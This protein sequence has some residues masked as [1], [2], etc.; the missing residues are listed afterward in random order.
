M[1]IGSSDGLHA[2]LR[3]C[4]PTAPKVPLSRGEILSGNSQPCHVE[5]NPCLSGPFSLFNVFNNFFCGVNEEF[6]TLFRVSRRC[7]TLVWI[8]F[9]RSEKRHRMRKS[10]GKLPNFI[11]VRKT[12]PGSAQLLGPVPY[13]FLTCGYC[14]N[15]QVKRGSVEK[16]L[17]PYSATS[18]VSVSTASSASATSASSSTVSSSVTPTR[19]LTVAEIS[20]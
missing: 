19:T 7:Q 4:V 13:A 9:F 10:A 15:T 3:C 1:T 20:R 14:R 6:S 17:E 12:G 16:C 8:T 18:A 5:K 11:R 2:G